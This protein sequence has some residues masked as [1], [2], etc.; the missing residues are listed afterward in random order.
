MILGKCWI[1]SLY[2]DEPQFD[3]DISKAGYYDICLS[4]N[5]L[6]QSASWPQ[7]DFVITMAAS[8]ENSPFYKE[9][10]PAIKMKS[11]RM[12]GSS[13]Y[14]FAPLP[15]KYLITNPN[16]SGFLHD[17]A[18]LIRKHVSSGAHVLWI[19]AVAVSSLLC[20]VFFIIPFLGRH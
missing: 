6:R 12:T 4:R 11:G 7:T 8:C 15:G 14:F 20:V 18:L 19:G 13:G 17:D 5:I 1:R 2:A 10:Y 16:A 3:V 9:T